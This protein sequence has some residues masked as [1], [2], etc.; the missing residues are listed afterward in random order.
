MSGAETVVDRRLSNGFRIAKLAMRSDLTHWDRKFV[1]S[2]SHRPR[3]TPKQQQI[4]ER[5]I[6]QYLEGKTP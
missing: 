6:T 1:A 2:I 5:L 4:L 3:L